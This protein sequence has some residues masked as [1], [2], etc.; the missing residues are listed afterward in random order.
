MLKFNLFIQQEYKQVG[1][2]LSARPS[3]E[4]PG[5]SGIGHRVCASRSLQQVGEA[6]NETSNIKLILNL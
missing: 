5:P 3:A 4:H 6:E 1:S 2:L